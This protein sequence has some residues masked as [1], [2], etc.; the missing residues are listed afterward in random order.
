MKHCVTAWVCPML[1]SCSIQTH[2]Q[3][4]S[5]STWTRPRA[6]LSSCS[7]QIQ[8][9]AQ[10]PSCSI[11]THAQHP[12]CSTRTSPMHNTHPVLHRS[13]LTP[14]LLRTNPALLSQP[15]ASVTGK[16]ARAKGTTGVQ[17]S[18]IHSSKAAFEH[19]ALCCCLWLIPN[20][21]GHQSQLGAGDGALPD[22]Q[23]D[24]QL[25]KPSA[26]CREAP[27]L[28]VRPTAACSCSLLAGLLPSTEP[29]SAP[30]GAPPSKGKRAAMQTP[31]DGILRISST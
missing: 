31:G 30:R 21:A 19:T 27:E 23:C 28:H 16:P 5:C 17:S 14:T 13:S 6:Q 7:V 25:P 4:S 8:P 12:C 20:P 10:H 11:Q 29:S 1:P 2:A 22:V 24:Q 15:Q 3:H 18:C 9:Q 26:S